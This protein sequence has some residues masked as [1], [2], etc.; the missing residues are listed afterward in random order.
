MIE[1]TVVVKNKHG[2]HARPA[3]CIVKLAA[4][5]KS[6]IKIK[7]DGTE[8]NA[9]SIMGIISLAAVLNTELT[10]IAEGEDAAAAAEA[11]YNLFESKFEEE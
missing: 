5:F 11:I 4:G 10:I 6:D 8:I 2:I 9:K 3:A 7:K 1:K